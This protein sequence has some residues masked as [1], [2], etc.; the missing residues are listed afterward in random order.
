MIG[1]EDGLPSP[2]TPFVAYAEASHPAPAPLMFVIDYLSIGLAVPW[3]SQ[4]CTVRVQPN[5][6]LNS[7]KRWRQEM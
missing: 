5:Q 7:K 6:L 4:D 1:V 3:Y 2:I